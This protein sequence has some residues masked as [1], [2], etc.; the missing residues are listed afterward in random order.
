[1]EINILKREIL[2]HLSSALW[3]LVI[4]ASYK[5][6]FVS[7]LANPRLDSWLGSKIKCENGID[8]IL[9]QPYRKIVFWK[10]LH[11]SK[12]FATSPYRNRDYFSVKMTE[13]HSKAK[14]GENWSSYKNDQCK[15]KS[16]SCLGFTIV[17]F[18][19]KKSRF[20]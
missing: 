2:L 6:S 16:A 1:M 7:F 15:N 17:Q 5:A 14:L 3:Y 13:T 12:V 20:K 4:D 8:C 19:L 18:F 11:F 10:Y 9:G